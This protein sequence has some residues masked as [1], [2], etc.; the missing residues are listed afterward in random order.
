MRMA[1]SVIFELKSGTPP[2]TIDV[3][4]FMYAA[5]LYT[6]FHSI[7]DAVRL[8]IK[9]HDLHGT[10]RQAQK[11]VSGHRG[12]VIIFSFGRCHFLHLT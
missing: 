11:R 3:G 7:C 8:L 5:D 12:P 1:R 10:E 2:C 6:T 9:R 4:P